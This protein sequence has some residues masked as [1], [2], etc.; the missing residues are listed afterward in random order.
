MAC[1]D[2]LSKSL[3]L[4][5]APQASALQR[6]Q[7]V[8]SFDIF[9]MLDMLQDLRGTIAQQEA[10]SSG[11]VKVVIVDSVTAVVAPLLGGQQ[12]EGLA[13]MM[14]LARELKIL[15]RDLGVAVVVTNHLTRDWDGR[16]FKPAL[17]RSWSFVPSTRILL[18]VTE[19]AGTLGSSQRTVCLTKSPR[20]PTG[21]QEMIDIG[22]LG[23]EEQ[24]PEL[25]GKQT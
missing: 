25:P 17:G 1:L 4:F 10:T 3:L 2:P 8:R 12:R 20:Q 15:A 13:L 11:A 9:R 5:L 6:I 24:S 7:V 16:R 21:L 14:Q 18:D 22:T 19:G 23:T